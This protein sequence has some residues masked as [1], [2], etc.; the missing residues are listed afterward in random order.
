MQ[1]FGGNNSGDRSGGE[2]SR[3]IDLRA[4]AM[5]DAMGMLDEV[6]AAAFD[7]AFRDATPS[8]QAELRE[9]QAAV[10]SDPAFLSLENELPAG[11]KARTLARVMTAVERQ[12]ADFAPIAHIGRTAALAQRG[13]AKGRGGDAVTDA[14]ELAGLRADLDSFVRSSYRWRAAAIALTAA[15]V[16]ALVF[17][18]SSNLFV[19]RV[20]EI[21]FGGA[22]P[23]GMLAAIDAEDAL[24]R[25][26][27]CTYCRAA[28]GL[29]GK[30]PA[31]G[32]GSLTIAVSEPESRITCV[33]FGLEVGARYVIRHVSDGGAV[34]EVGSFLA[35]NSTWA[36]EFALP[37]LAP[38]FLR[39]GSIEVVDASGE[40][41]MRG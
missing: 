36:S 22:T 26:A 12:E 2:P 41:V 21:V 11:L 27:K 24:L 20:T 17:Q 6:D 1:R 35:S 13:R 40:V 30:G 37:A 4:E 10:S 33:G 7:R 5:L 23:R 16:V 38:G 34:T 29:P 15:L 39:T 8:L 28:A 25:V 32:L 9:L 14:V 3:G 19:H 18:V 31:R